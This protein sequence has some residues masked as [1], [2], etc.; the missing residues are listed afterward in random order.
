VVAALSIAP[1]PLL[2][3]PPRP[4]RQVLYMYSAIDDFM[5]NNLHEYSGK[6]LVTAEVSDVGAAPAK[7]AEKPKGAF[8]GCTV[9]MCVC[10]QAG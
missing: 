10:R 3:P 7:A 8:E 2:P 5:M 4:H 9:C 1:R 6:K